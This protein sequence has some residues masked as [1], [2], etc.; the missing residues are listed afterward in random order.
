M[1][2]VVGNF[3]FRI[4]KD[5]MLLYCREKHLVASLY[6]FVCRF[7]SVVAI[8]WISLKAYFGDVHE[9]LLEK[10]SFVKIGP[11]ISRCLLEDLSMLQCIR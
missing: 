11:K 5:E 9:S 3:I 8:S 2:R 7:V 6:V 1:S 10:P 4:E